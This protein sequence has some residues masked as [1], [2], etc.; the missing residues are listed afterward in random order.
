MLKKSTKKKVQDFF[1]S[2]VFYVLLLGLVI[3]AALVVVSFNR[4]KQYDASKQGSIVEQG[5]KGIKDATQT[6]SVTVNDPNNL[7]GKAGTQMV[8]AGANA[9]ADTDQLVVTVNGSST[10]KII[11][12]DDQSAVV[13]GRALFKIDQ[14][15]K[16]AV[17]PLKFDLFNDKGN[18][19]TPEYLKTSNEQKI[20]FYV[21]SADLR[22]F[23]HLNPVFEDGKWSVKANL[24][25][26]GSYYAYSYAT[27]VKNQKILAV[28]ELVVQKK[29]EGK[30]NFPG[31]TPQLLAI[32]DGISAKASL[33]PN[34]PGLN[35]MSF[36]LTKDQKALALEPVFGSFGNVV[37]IR[38]GVW[39]NFSQAELLAQTDD[40]GGLASF[41]FDLKTEGKYT[42][43][44]EFKLG[45][46]TYL[47]PITF[48]I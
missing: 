12:A 3:I 28:N 48:E 9:T 41:S 10:K 27:T 11:Y 43:F 40:Q 46:K 25:T 34:T 23:Q 8:A 35:V 42:A 6:I 39:D 30:I 16:L 45:G 36:S 1:F 29:S 26:P 32:T 7:A 20:H 47:F 5:S 4:S 33:S 14:F 24:P 38:Q 21:V 37:I 13:R 2:P 18:L 17:Q 22:E 15:K 31:L 44:C 19:L